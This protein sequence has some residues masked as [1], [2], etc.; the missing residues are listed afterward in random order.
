MTVAYFHVFLIEKNSKNTHHV[1]EPTR[2]ILWTRHRSMSDFGHFKRDQMSLKGYP[3]SGS[4]SILCTEENITN[5]AEVLAD[6]LKTMLICFFDVG[7]LVHRECV[8][9]G[10]AV[11]PQTLANGGEKEVPGVVGERTHK[12]PHKA[13]LVMH[14][15]SKNGMALLPYLPY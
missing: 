5:E 9:L 6:R 2:R 14:F 8:P 7:I 10:R 13:L 4:L 3:R 11:K 1:A 12:P 15:L